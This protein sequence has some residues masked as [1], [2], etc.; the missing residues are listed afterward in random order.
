MATPQRSFRHCSHAPGGLFEHH[1][2]ER[3]GVHRH[4]AGSGASTPDGAQRFVAT[5]L[6]E[7]RALAPLAASIARAE[8][9][10]V[11]EGE[12]GA[13]DAEFVA[14][15]RGAHEREQRGQRAAELQGEGEARALRRPR[16]FR[17]ERPRATRRPG[18]R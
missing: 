4:L 14:D 15:V 12:A 8:Q 17:G 18:L 16:R 1:R 13:P 5:L 3:E 10:G 11:G 6:I 9:E 2:G 7:D